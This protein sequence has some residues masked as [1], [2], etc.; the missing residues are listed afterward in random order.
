MAAARAALAELGL[1][2]DARAETLSA[3]DFVA[4]S[5]KLHPDA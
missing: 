4:L 1:P 3:E 2:E 5:A